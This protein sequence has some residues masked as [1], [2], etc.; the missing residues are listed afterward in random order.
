MI[1]SFTKGFLG[2]NGVKFDEYY[3]RDLKGKHKGLKGNRPLTEDQ[4]PTPEILRKILQFLPLHGR[5]FALAASSSGMRLG[6]SLRL[7]LSDIELDKEPVRI[8]IR[9]EYTKS[10]LARPSFLSKEAVDTLNEWLKVR[11]KWLQAA[12]RKS[13]IYPK[14]ARDDRVFPFSH[15]TVYAMW[16]AALEKSGY[17]DRDPTTG[18][19]K[20]HFHTLRKYF[21]SRLPRGGVPVDVTQGIMGEEG[22][23]SAEYRSLKDDP[24]TMARMYKQGEPFLAVFSDQAEMYEFREETKGLRLQIED[25]KGRLWQQ[26]EKV[27]R[28]DAKYQVETEEL[29]NELVNHPKFWNLLGKHVGRN[30][31]GPND[32]TNTKRAFV[33]PSS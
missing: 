4:A 19:Y 30:I 15:G 13:H 20:Y 12:S 28:A 1:L 10:G 33:S 25:L 14:G 32:L 17:A 2:R 6:E 11:E 5:A 27:R 3:W 7:K 29:L 22:Y 18:I 24:E 26:E 16:H 21:R 23:L 8:H 9:R 31:P